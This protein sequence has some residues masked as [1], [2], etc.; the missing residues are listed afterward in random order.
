MK[1]QYTALRTIYTGLLLHVCKNISNVHRMLSLATLITS[2][3]SYPG[4][5]GIYR[6]VDIGSRYCMPPP[7]GH[8]FQD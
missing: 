1:A 2:P 8:L 7:L 3:S 4:I 5:C 6:Y